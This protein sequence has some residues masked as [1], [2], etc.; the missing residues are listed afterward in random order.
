MRLRLYLSAIVLLSVACLAAT[1][2]KFNNITVG[3]TGGNVGKYNNVTIGTT[4]GN[5]GA[6]NGLV[7]P[8][9]GGATF[10]CGN[11]ASPGANSDSNASLPEASPCTTGS[12][13]AGY[14]ILTFHWYAQNAV[15]PDNVDLGVYSDNGSQTAPATTSSLLCHTGTTS[16]TSTVGDNSLS[17]SGHSCPTLSHN[18]TYWPAMTLAGSFNYGFTSGN[19]SGFSVTGQ[20]S[21]NS[22]S[23]LPANFGTA[24]S[25]GECFN[26]WMVIQA[27]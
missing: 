12:N 17:A 20:A 10:V 16:I 8:G 1:W 25:F 26:V 18:T 6:Y 15:G 21:S 2:G 5:I 11:N 7:S 23:A 27:N 13:A 19:C 22:G 4:T 14:T 9:G 3:S 24:S